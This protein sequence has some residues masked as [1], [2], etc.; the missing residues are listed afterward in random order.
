MSTHTCHYREGPAGQ[1]LASSTAAADTHGSDGRQTRLPSAFNSHTIH[2][3]HLVKPSCEASPV[4]GAAGPQSSAAGER[5]SAGSNGSARRRESCRRVTS[6][7]GT[8]DFDTRNLCLSGRHC[9]HYAGRDAECGHQEAGGPRHGPCAGAAR[10]RPAALRAAAPSASAGR[11]PPAAASVAPAPRPDTHPLHRLRLLP[12]APGPLLSRSPG[13]PGGSGGS[14]RHPQVRVLPGPG[15][16]GG[17]DPA[18][19]GRDWPG[20]GGRRA[21]NMAAGSGGC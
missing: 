12:E 13:P 10:G 21:E 17:R 8:E 2:H 7:C 9:T 6:P 4:S 5:Q 11:G 19:A 20:G 1:C 18:G 16:E 14:S 15:V 3:L